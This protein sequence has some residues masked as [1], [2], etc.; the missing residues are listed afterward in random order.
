[1]KK[2]TQWPIFLTDQNPLRPTLLSL[3]NLKRITIS[4]E[5]AN[6]NLKTQYLALLVVNWSAWSSS[7]PTIRV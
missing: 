6:K 4:D 5:E 3:I 7:T 2:V 1:M